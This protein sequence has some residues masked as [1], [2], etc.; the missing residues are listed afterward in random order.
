MFTLTSKHTMIELICNYQLRNDFALFFYALLPAVIS[1][2]AGLWAWKPNSQ[3]RLRSFNFDAFVLGF[4]VILLIGMAI[5]LNWEVCQEP[6]PSLH[7]Y[8][9]LQPL[10][11]VIGF[12]ARVGWFKLRKSKSYST[13]QYLLCCTGI[14]V[15]LVLVIKAIYE[16]F[17]PKAVNFGLILLIS[18]GLCF[19][20]VQR[21]LI[22][23]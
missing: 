4:I 5:L 13:V 23:R 3:G 19:W 1:I 17:T 6:R 11:F 20:V 12:F 18:Y 15:L 22:K 16:L 21:L 10:W 7:L 14:L 8:L 2:A 9:R